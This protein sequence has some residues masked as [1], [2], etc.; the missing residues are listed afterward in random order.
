MRS[1]RRR[2]WALL[3][4]VAVVAGLLAP[5]AVSAANRA[6]SGAAAPLVKPEPEPSGAE[7]RTSVEGSRVVAYCHNPYPTTD[8]VRL[9]TE[10]ARWWDVDADGAAV[11][12]QPGRT[13]KIED[14]CWKEVDSAWVSHSVTS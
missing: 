10:C 1:T 9:H 6:G 2:T 8:L 5:V 4:G 3:A 12:V 14:R 7:C 11:A 13:V